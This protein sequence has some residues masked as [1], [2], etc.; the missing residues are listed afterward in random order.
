MSYSLSRGERRDHP[1]ERWYP[2]DYD[3]THILTTLGS[4]KLGHGW[5]AGMRFR[6]ATGSPFTGNTQRVQ[7]L[8]TGGNSCIEDAGLG[9]NSARLAPFHALDARIDRQFTFNTW[10]LAASLEVQNAYNRANE[11]IPAYGSDCTTLVPF[12][13]LPILPV[14]GLRGEF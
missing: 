6:Y 1:G 9:R 11:E 13:G 2:S 7:N 12:Y 8:D 3:Q 10:Q 4:Y 5:T 14:I